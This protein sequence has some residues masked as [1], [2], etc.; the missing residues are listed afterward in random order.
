VVASVAFAFWRR[1]VG[2]IALSTTC[3]IGVL[4]GNRCTALGVTVVFR[5]RLFVPEAVIFDDPPEEATQPP[6]LSLDD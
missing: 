2:A 4:L 6:G 3:G 5:E 1:D